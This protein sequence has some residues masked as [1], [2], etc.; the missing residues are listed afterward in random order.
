MSRF[1]WAVDESFLGSS[2]TDSGVAAA[3][4]P[5]GQER[6]TLVLFHVKQIDWHFCFT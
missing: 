6:M 4:Y 5:G 2:Y 3:R 1:G